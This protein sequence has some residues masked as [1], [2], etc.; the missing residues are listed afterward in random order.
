MSFLGRFS[1]TFHTPKLFVRQPFKNMA[2]CPGA[3]MATGGGEIKLIMPY[4]KARKRQVISKPPGIG[5]V[6]LIVRPVGGQRRCFNEPCLSIGADD[7]TLI[8]CG[9]GN[10]IDSQNS[11]DI[12]VVFPHQPGQDRRPAHDIFPGVVRV[13]PIRLGGILLIS[14]FQ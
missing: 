4:R 12:P 3:P 14:P 10:I 7:L 11:P 13:N 9:A 1:F 2:S 6:S 8:G 5:A